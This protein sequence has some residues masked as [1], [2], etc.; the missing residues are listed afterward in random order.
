MVGD[1]SPRRGSVVPRP[2]VLALVLLS[3]LL[4]GCE[5]PPE[6]SATLCGP[7]GVLRVGLLDP[8]EGQALTRA[9]P[10]SEAELS[11]FKA[12]LLQ[13]SRCDV[14]LEP[15]SSFDRA[16]SSLAD[17]QWDAAFLPP[18]LLAFSLAAKTGYVP[19]RSLGGSRSSSSVLLVKE[20]SRFRS[21][22]DLEQARIGL[23]PRGSLTGFYLPLYNLHGLSLGKVSYA[24]NPAA[25]GSMLERGEVDAIA[26]DEALPLPFASVRRLPVNP[27]PLPLGALVLSGSLI[28]S[29]HTLFLKTLDA[30]A[31]Q[32]PV[33]LGYASGVLPKQ[34][35]MQPLRT[36]VEYVEGWQLPLDG[37]PYQVFGRKGG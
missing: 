26:W 20:G 2:V 21:V 11:S 19:I 15:L 7:T 36:I 37:E 31:A 5:S 8:S 28:R 16:R 34:Q 32:M 14:Q 13:A 9:V 4:V 29:D 1:C 33:G 6:S 3:V 25:L 30:S 10:F 24:L 23:L 27:H 22:K 17:R 18:G 35:A 12:L